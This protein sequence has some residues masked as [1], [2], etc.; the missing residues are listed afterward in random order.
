MTDTELLRFYH[1]T[2][3]DAAAEIISDGSRNVVEQMGYRALASGIWIALLDRFGTAQE[4]ARQNWRHADLLRGPGLTPLRSAHALEEG[5]LFIYGPFYATLNIGWAYRYAVRNPFR[6]ELLHAIADGLRFLERSGATGQKQELERRYS[7]IS[8][9]VNR[10]SPPVVL[11]LGGIQESR[12]S[13]Q[14]GSAQVAPRIEQYLKHVEARLDDP[15]S[16]RIDE[17]VPGD[18]IAVHDLRD[19][20]PNEILDPPWQPDP[21]RVEAARKNVQEWLK[22]GRHPG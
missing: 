5:H 15:A 12:L 3:A 11:E 18:V 13:N 2:G 7:T 19:W 10:P 20:S 9:L 14:N 22:R 1:G 4:V 6:S 17:V 8:E 21:G 16:F